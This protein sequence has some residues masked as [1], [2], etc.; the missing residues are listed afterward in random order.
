MNS[1]LIRMAASESKAGSVIRARVS[2]L[3]ATRGLVWQPRPRAA[4]VW[5]S[6]TRDHWGL[7]FFRDE[8][9]KPVHQNLQ[10]FYIWIKMGEL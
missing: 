5:K 7:G 4:K 3:F 10:F 8:I 9:D 6:N 2:G 1:A